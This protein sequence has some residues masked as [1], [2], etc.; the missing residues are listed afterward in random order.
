MSVCN[1]DDDE[2]DEMPWHMFSQSRTKKKYAFA[3]KTRRFKGDFVFAY[4]LN[5]WKILALPL[6]EGKVLN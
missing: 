6:A 5:C 2:G 3:Q 1:D 4:V